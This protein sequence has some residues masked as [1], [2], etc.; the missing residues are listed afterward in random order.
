[1]K[2]QADLAGIEIE[3]TVD[4][5]KEKI[6][7]ETASELLG[8]ASLIHIVKGKKTL[9]LGPENRDEILALAIGPSGNLRAPTIRIGDEYFT[10]HSSG[11]YEKI[12]IRLE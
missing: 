11:L 7:A 1:M 10:G 6:S 4:A 3:K 12:R 2:A 5:T 8:K 9:E